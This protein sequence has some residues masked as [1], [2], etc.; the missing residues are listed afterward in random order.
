MR[1]ALVSVVI[2]CFNQAHFLADAVESVLVQT[3]TPTELIVVDDGST[4]DTASVASRYP[5]A[6]LLRQP[7]M[8]LAAARNS[9]LDAS[10]GDYLAFL[11]AD[12][13]FMPGALTA[14]LDCLAQHPECAFAWGR[15]AIRNHRGDVWEPPNDPRDRGDAFAALLRE[16]HIAMHATVL[17][18]RDPLKLIGGFDARLR[19][20]EDYDLYLRI[21]RRFPIVRHE[22][23]VAEYRKHGNNMSADSSMMLSTVLQVLEAQR[24]HVDGHPLYSAAYAN[25]VRFWKR[26]YGA[27]SLGKIARELRAFRV[28]DAVE[29]AA[30]LCRTA[31]TSTVLVNAPL[32]LARHWISNRRRGRNR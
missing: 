8:G 10:R 32:W 27:R 20:C 4:D 22:N 5:Q 30:C 2:P 9:G 7:N 3:H 6:R 24:P 18:R 25:G 31:G 28:A 29:Y 11:D 19:A 23:L 26:F 1:R 15:Y 21:A 16:N 13:R 14:G 12:D 17:Y